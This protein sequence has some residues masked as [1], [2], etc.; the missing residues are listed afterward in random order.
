MNVLVVEDEEDIA[1]LIKYNLQEEGFQ[2]S[3]CHHGM[4]VLP[5]IQKNLPDLIILDLMLPGIGGIDLCKLIREKYM[6]PIVMVTART[7]E[8]DAVLGLELGADDY[9][10]K[11]FSVLEL[12]A[13]VRSVIRRYNG[14]EK[15]TAEGNITLGKI[16]LNPTAYK[17]SIDGEKADLTL[18]E[19]KILHLF[20]SN[21]GVAFT[22]DKLLDKIW[23][24]D[25][26]ITDRAVDVHIKRLRDKLLSQKERLET[27][28]GIGY[29]FSDA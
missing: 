17:V 29:R 25:T 20:M 11:P 22:R 6:V 4:E 10:R 21:P 12:K 2:V 3:I 16:E 27:V 5:T 26:Y 14:N 28:R 9:I 19:Y 24:H 23:G 7:G 13:R 1:E 15:E 8:T 18:I